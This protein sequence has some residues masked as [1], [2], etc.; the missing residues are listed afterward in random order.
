MRYKSLRTLLGGTL[1]KNR[2]EASWD[3]PPSKSSR[4]QNDSEAQSSNVNT[5]A[6]MPQSVSPDRNLLSACMIT[7][8]EESK[9]CA[10]LL[11]YYLFKN[12]CA[13]HSQKLVP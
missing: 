10:N 13:I 5:H 7:I 12:L 1:L 2:E 11:K 4:K 8:A 9:E 3:R 6:A